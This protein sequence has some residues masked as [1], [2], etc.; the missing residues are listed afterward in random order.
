MQEAYAANP[1][2]E[3]VIETLELDHVGFAEPVRIASNVED[4]VL[5]PLVA[6]G[7]PVTF[8]AL[9]VAV[10]LPGV[11][12]DGPTPMRVRIDNVSGL[13]LPYLRAAIQSTAPISV[14]YRAYTSADL[15]GPGDVIDGLQ[16]RSVDLTATT[17]EGE[18]SFREVAMEAFPRATYDGTFYPALSN[19]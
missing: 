16:L 12:E 3:V 5:L 7:D 14:V 6:G 18:V 4:D 17:A 2:G 11:S 1:A 9:A 15:T 10:T 8:R 19:L 13:L